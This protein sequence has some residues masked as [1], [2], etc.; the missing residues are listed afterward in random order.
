MLLP[1]QC[2]PRPI[3][4]Q[5]G[6]FRLRDDILGQFVSGCASNVFLGGLIGAKPP[7][8]YFFRRFG[9]NGIPGLRGQF[10]PAS[11]PPVRARVSSSG[12]TATR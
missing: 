10:P 8:R 6:H 4:V 7:F 5:F 1:G 12:P 9:E 11:S 2:H 3:F